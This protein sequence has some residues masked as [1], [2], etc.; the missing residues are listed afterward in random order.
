MKS[1]D[2]NF[3]LLQYLQK[4]NYYL[5]AK[6]T[7]HLQT[8]A[9]IIANAD[10]HSPVIHSMYSVLHKS[11]RTLKPGP[12]GGPVREVR[13]PRGSAAKRPFRG[14]ALGFFPA[15]KVSKISCVSDT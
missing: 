12:G 6:I 4:S 7:I 5:T 2:Y 9:D 3:I 8:S 15:A 14:P 11:S 1:I 13:P 10:F